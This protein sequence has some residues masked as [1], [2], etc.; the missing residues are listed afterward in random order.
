[1][2]GMTEINHAINRLIHYAVQKNLMK[3]EDRYY[4]GNRLIDLLQVPEFI[5][6]N[7]IEE[8]FDTAQPILDIMLDDAAT[9]GLIE[10]TTEERDAFDTRI[11]D[12]VMPRPS[13]VIR[14]FHDDYARSPKAATDEFYKMS[15]ASNYIRKD[16]IAKNIVWQTPTDYG[17]LDITINLSKPEK[18]PRDIARAKE[19]AST[20][21]PKCLLCR[22]NE[23][24]AGHP[25]WPARETHRL[26]PIR[27]SGHRWF[28]QYSPYTYYNEHCIV[29]NRRHIPMKITRRSFE[30]LL[31]FVT[32]LPHYFLGSNADLPIVGGSILSH[33]HYQGGRYT[34][35]MAKAVIEKSY[36]VPGFPNIKV[37]RVKWPMSTIRLEAHYDDRDELVDLATKILDLWRDYSDESA[38]ILAETDGTP[39]NTVTPIAR[40]KGEGYQ[41]DIVLRNNRTTDEYPLG[42]FHP[43]EDV[44]HIK[45]ENIG[46]IEVMGLAVLPAR[47]KTEMGELK[48][49]WEKGTEDISG[50]ESIKKHAAWYKEIRAKHPEAKPEELDKI[51]EYEIGKVFETVLIHAGVYKR[52]PEGMAAFDRFMQA[53]SEK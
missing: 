19:H 18:D 48:Q 5:P 40:R 16:R 41:L 44:H 22:E 36:L 1:M 32:I 42:I 14:R 45:K 25:G 21:Y 6:E 46:L 24:Y 13:E 27:L 3:E 38:Q 31:D 51:L 23:G 29:L 17:P 2:I 20:T 28:M 52:T 30:N 39:H 12:C 35:P 33:D 50:I 7:D 49:E 26:I 53:V 43:H 9:K 47:L 4:A 8:M 11:M 34:F 37:G 10:N 15:Q